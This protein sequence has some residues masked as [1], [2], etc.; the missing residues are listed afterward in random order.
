MFDSDIL[1]T[2]LENMDAD[3]VSFLLDII[4]PDIAFIISRS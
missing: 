4:N 1:S 2:A 3:A